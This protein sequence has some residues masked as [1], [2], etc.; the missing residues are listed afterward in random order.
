LFPLYYAPVKPVK[1]EK[2][3]LH[4]PKQKHEWEFPTRVFI[5]IKP[6]TLENKL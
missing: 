3:S 2:T 5:T 6:A 4:A 1:Q